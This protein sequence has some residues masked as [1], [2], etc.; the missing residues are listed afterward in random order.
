L[1]VV[2]SVEYEADYCLHPMTLF[3]P[4]PEKVADEF[5]LGVM[6]CHALTIQ[7]RA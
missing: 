6:V 5:P 7:R 2:G 4:Q 1:G 3:G